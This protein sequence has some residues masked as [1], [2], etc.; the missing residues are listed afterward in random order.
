MNTSLSLSF[1][2]IYLLGWLLKHERNALDSLIKQ[3]VKNGLAVDLDKIAIDDQD[4]MS[5]QLYGT[6][7][8]FLVYLEDTLVQNLDGIHTNN[9]PHQLLHPA[10]SK[11]MNNSLDIQTI[12][13]SIQQAREKLQHKTNNN[14]QSKNETIE[15]GK[16]ILFE[17]LLK[18]WNPS[19]NETY[20]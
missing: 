10:L 11:F 18:N 17:Q 5:E 2:L 12:K 3:A 15:E 4:K 19:K 9:A 1:E 6:V 16:S 20:H 8:D 7:L 14:T 13:L